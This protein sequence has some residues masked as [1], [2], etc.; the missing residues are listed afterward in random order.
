VSADKRDIRLGC[1]SCGGVCESDGCVCLCP[2]CDDEF[3]LFR[4]CACGAL[5][6]L[7]WRLRDADLPAELA[8]HV[9]AGGRV[10]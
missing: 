2:C 4:C 8:K 1:L 6:Q 7:E 3:V 5:H 10:S 9:S